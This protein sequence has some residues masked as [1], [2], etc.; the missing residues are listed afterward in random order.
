MSTTNG[1]TYLVWTSNILLARLPR[2]LATY[3]YCTVRSGRGSCELRICN[4]GS[5]RKRLNRDDA[6]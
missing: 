6:P 2:G 5:R 3:F 4:V 1:N